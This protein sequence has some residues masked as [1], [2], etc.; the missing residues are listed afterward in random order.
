MKQKK[1][2]LKEDTSSEKMTT[3]ST[4]INEALKKGYVVDFKVE[5]NGRLWDGNGCYYSP[6]EVMIDN[7]Y[8]FE[9]ESDPADNSILYLITTN[10]GRQGTLIDAYG[11]Y[12]DSKVSEFIRD[13]NDI[14]KQEHDDGTLNKKRFLKSIYVIAGLLLVV[15]AIITYNQLTKQKRML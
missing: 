13:V 5:D 8:R 9:G 10:D 14:Q 2:Q 15:S 3:L 12:D 4:S 1:N 6:D 7:F 11:V